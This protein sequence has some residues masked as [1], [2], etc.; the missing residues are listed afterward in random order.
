MHL[1]SALIAGTLFGL[2]L[3]ISGM[4]QPGKVI[5]F[6]DVTGAWDPS[7]AFVMATALAI[8]GPTYFFVTRRRQ[9]PVVAAAFDLPTKTQI[10]PRLVAGGVVFGAGWGLAGFCPGTAVTSLPTGE[11]SVLAMVGGV[12]VGILLTW[13]VQSAVQH[14]DVPV[15]A[16]F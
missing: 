1:L 5:G 16:D 7:L 13:G 11:L 8:F 4:T 10:T 9:K 15:R 6:L 2:G 3:A 14:E 12:F